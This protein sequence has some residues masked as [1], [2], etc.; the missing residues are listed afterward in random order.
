MLEKSFFLKRILNAASV[1][2]LVVSR[3]SLWIVYIVLWVYHKNSYLYKV[4]VIFHGRIFVVHSLD[5]LPINS[6][7]VDICSHMIYARLP[8]KHSPI[9]YIVQYV[10]IY[11]LC[12]RFYAIK[13][14]NLV[15]WKLYQTNFFSTIRYTH[16]HIPTY[17]IFVITYKR[18]YA[19]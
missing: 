1:P 14:I 18:R 8:V 11:V 15:K 4:S 12:T 2:M 5:L 7:I 10:I 17:N 16:T 6:Y 13:R 9:N 3:F 19:K